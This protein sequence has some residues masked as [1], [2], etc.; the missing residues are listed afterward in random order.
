MI[1]SCDSPLRLCVLV[2]AAVLAFLPGCDRNDI[3]ITNQGAKTW[4]QIKISAGG[5]DFTIKQLDGG[6]TESIRFQSQVEGG[7]E[8]SGT[9]EGE[10][11]RAEFGYFTPNLST[12][13][14]IMFND[15]GSITINPAG[16]ENSQ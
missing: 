15:N 5:R 12:E 16:P 14:E 11:Y 8:I 6:T 7:G 9:L 3:K 2:I 13:E 10:N 4:K 1:E